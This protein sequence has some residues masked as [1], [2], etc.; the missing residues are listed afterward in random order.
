MARS[1]LFIFCVIWGICA[2]QAQSLKDVFKDNQELSDLFVNPCGIEHPFEEYDTE[3]LRID[4]D[5]IQSDYKFLSLG[6]YGNIF[7][8]IPTVPENIGGVKIR[9]TTI[10]LNDSFN[11]IMY[12][13]DSCDNYKDMYT[14]L[15][16]S[17]KNY[18][19]YND[20]E[21]YQDNDMAVFMLTDKYGVGISLMNDKKITMAFLMD[22]KNLKKFMNMSPDNNNTKVVP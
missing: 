12:E 5:K 15:C 9:Q 11:G 13:S 7:R 14:Y 20:N 2:T 4:L 6:D 19:I 21:D 18:S 17:L 1:V 8:V 22:M 3:S 10:V 16:N